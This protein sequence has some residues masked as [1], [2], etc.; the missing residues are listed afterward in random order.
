[1][2]SR[3]V[4]PSVFVGVMVLSAVLFIGGVIFWLVTTISIFR[5][6]NAPVG[7][8]KSKIPALDIKSINTIFPGTIPEEKKK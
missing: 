8:P 4:K 5:L 6:A 7:T 2:I 3:L 1:M